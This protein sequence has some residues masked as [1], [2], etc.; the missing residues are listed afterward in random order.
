MWPQRSPHPYKLLTRFLRALTAL[1]ES[2]RIQNPLSKG[3]LYFF[4][5]LA[6]SLC[7]ICFLLLFIFL[8]L[9]VFSPLSLPSCQFHC[10]TSSPSFFCLEEKIK[11]SNLHLTGN[12]SYSL[13]RLSSAFSLLSLSCTTVMN[14]THEGTRNKNIH[15][16]VL[17]SLA[18]YLPLLF[19][20]FLTYEKRINPHD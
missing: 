15:T 2:F 3:A 16:Y 11:L 4:R 7:L 20:L 9:S 17:H 6:L 10:P 18:S 14:E 19:L 5:S 8:S 12:I 1:Q 13:S